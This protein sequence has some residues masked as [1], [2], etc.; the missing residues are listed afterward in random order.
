MNWFWLLYNHRRA[1][2]SETWIRRRI[3]EVEE[4]D[5]LD[6]HVEAIRRAIE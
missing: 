1:A 2:L 6:L 5:A 4:T 3:D